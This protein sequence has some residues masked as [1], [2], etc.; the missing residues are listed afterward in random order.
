MI[1]QS[2]R[3]HNRSEGINSELL[4]WRAVACSEGVSIG[5]TVVLEDLDG[6]FG[7]EEVVDEVDVQGLDAGGIGSAFAGAGVEAG[8]TDSWVAGVA[9][10]VR[11]RGDWA[12]MSGS[13]FSGSSRGRFG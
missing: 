11:R 13:R 8:G 1:L 7:R 3:T 4:R 2:Q 12:K 9:V 10:G 5:I 6:A